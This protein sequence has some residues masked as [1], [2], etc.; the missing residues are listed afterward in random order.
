MVAHVHAE[1]GC[2]D[3]RQLAPIPVPPAGGALLVVV[4]VGRREQV[5]EDQLG[6]VDA[7]LRVP[8]HRNA[9]PVVLDDQLAFGP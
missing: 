2:E 6:D 8:H 3:A 7:V 1:L 5:A 9:V 4:V